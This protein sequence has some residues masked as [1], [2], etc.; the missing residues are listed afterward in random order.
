VARTGLAPSKGY[1]APGDERSRDE[2]PRVGAA[3]SIR[4]APERALQG[5]ELLIARRPLDGLLSH[6]LIMAAAHAA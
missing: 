5:H 1:E 3:D 4:L 6:C 2:A